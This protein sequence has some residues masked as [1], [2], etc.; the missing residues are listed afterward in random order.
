MRTRSGF[1]QISL[2]RAAVY[3][4]LLRRFHIYNLNLNY[5][6]WIS[7]ELRLWYHQLAQNTSRFLN[8]SFDGPD[9][10]ATLLER[11]ESLVHQVAPHAE[12]LLIWK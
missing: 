3:P 12:A 11:T 1:D 5:Y 10:Q 6:N 2:L 7:L 8:V 4:E 9:H